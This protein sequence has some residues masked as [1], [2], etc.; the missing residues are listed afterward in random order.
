[1]GGHADLTSRPTDA[2]GSRWWVFGLV[3]LAAVAAV[4][5]IVV[6]V[7]KS[8][9]P[10][11]RSKD[12]ASAPSARGA[13]SKGTPQADGADSDSDPDLEASAD[14]LDDEPGAQPSD[15]PALPP[16]DYVPPKRPPREQMTDEEKRVRKERAVTMLETRLAQVEAEADDKERQGDADGAAELRVRAGRIR[17]KIERRKA[18]LGQAQ[19][20][21]T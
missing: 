14:A 17:K 8:G 7:Q 20:G 1:M 19:E 2:R 16:S 3:G 12:V 21:G 9:G 4:I 15:A 11:E 13:K 6:M 18:E 10:N 5:A